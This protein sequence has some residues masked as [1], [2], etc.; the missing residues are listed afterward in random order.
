M[1]RPRK[2]ATGTPGRA[3]SNSVTSIA[4]GTS[5][6]SRGRKS[7]AVVTDSPA[8]VEER[9]ARTSLPVSA[10]QPTALTATAV[11]SLTPDQAAIKLDQIISAT[12][13]PALPEE[14]NPVL[15]NADVPV[16]LQI[17]HREASDSPNNTLT[18]PMNKEIIIGRVKLNTVNGASHGFLLKRFDTNAVAATSMFKLAFPYA[19]PAAEQAEMAYLEQKYDCKSANGGTKTDLVPVAQIGEDGRKKPGRPR[20]ELRTYL[21]EGSS[22]VVLQG[23]WVPAGDAIRLA[24][25]YGLERY[26][27]PLIEAK[28]AEFHGKP[29]FVN[30][31]G[32]PILQANGSGLEAHQEIALAH[33]HP[34]PPP[35]GVVPKGSPSTPAVAQSQGQQQQAAATPTPVGAKKISSGGTTQTPSTKRVK[36]DRMGNTEDLS[37][38]NVRD[39]RRYYEQ[40][41]AWHGIGQD[42][43]VSP[44]S[45]VLD[46]LKT[47]AP[48]TQLS[49]SSNTVVTHPDGSKSVLTSKRTAELAA[50]TNREIQKEIAASKALAKQTQAEAAAALREGAG[51]VGGKKR[52][53]A[54]Q[55]PTADVAIFA[56]DSDAEDENEEG[57]DDNE[58]PRRNVVAR[59]IRTGTR[60]VR[61]RPI[62]TGAT[63]LAA[64][65]AA[66]A[67][68]AAFINP[69]VVDGAVQALQQGVASLHHFFF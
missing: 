2:S 6:R 17:I 45:D 39:N 60:A 8:K 19:T 25:E 30:E 52:R 55:A 16:K 48:R 62:A 57:T 46:K 29:Y 1:P 37:Q 33:G 7:A 65:G 38:A 59:T 66:A 67:G 51:T 61:R 35:R 40:E 63:A 27:M 21:P 42:E 68:A 58:L 34:L 69:A 24:K 64:V 20:K 12:R 36:T 32:T 10:S 5:T 14:R 47:T 18:T 54:N 4:S 50:K 11:Q 15:P 43:E 31:K 3:R 44:S 22:G 26:A 41:T 49:N 23:T 56:A 28:A 9:L 13:D 53:A